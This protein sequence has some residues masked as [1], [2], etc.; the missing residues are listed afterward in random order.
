MLILFS[1]KLHVCFL[2]QPE[3]RTVQERGSLQK[4]KKKKKGLHQSKIPTLDH[5][6]LL[7]QAV[8]ILNALLD[9]WASL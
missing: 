2:Q 4:G 1:I 8:I 6:K 9:I 3:L 7:S 5:K